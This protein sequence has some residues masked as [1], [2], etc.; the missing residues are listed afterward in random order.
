MKTNMPSGDLR[1]KNESMT[2]S[3][4]GLRGHVGCCSP[5]TVLLKT[6]VAQC[7]DVDAKCKHM[8]VAYTLSLQQLYCEIKSIMT[9]LNVGRRV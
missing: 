1:Q 3:K 7:N 6:T 5:F 2:L 8:H 4:N 9:E